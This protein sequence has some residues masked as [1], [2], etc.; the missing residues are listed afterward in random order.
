MRVRLD[1]FLLAALLI[2]DGPPDVVI[3]GFNMV[4]SK[5][6]KKEFELRAQRAE[7]YRAED[8]YVFD[9]PRSSIVSDKGDA[10]F[11]VEGSRA[12]YDTDEDRLEIES[13]AQVRTPENLVFKTKSVEMDTKKKIVRGKD[14]VVVFQKI[15]GEDKSLFDLRGKGLLVDISRGR[16]DILAN[17]TAQKILSPGDIMKIRSQSSYFDSGAQVLVFQKNVNLESEKFKANGDHLTVAL[18]PAPPPKNTKTKSGK[19]PEQNTPS[20]NSIRVESEN[21]STADMKDGTHFKAK[22]LQFRLSNSGDVDESNA[23]GSAYAELPGGAKL[24]AENL[25]STTREGQQVILLNDTVEIRVDNKIATCENG[26]YYPDSGDFLLQNVASINDGNQV[27]NGE[28]IRYSLK[29]DSVV[30]EKASGQLSRREFDLKDK[31]TNKKQK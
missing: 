5:R 18:N 1:S 19:A 29:D 11:E 10:T 21:F 20:I 23:L 15:N 9:L 7:V 4:Q 25:R 26:E 16:Y 14:D 28:K 24:K 2:P 12:L 22:G 30:V 31:P 27:I 17:S 8:F 3:K 13:N 6:E